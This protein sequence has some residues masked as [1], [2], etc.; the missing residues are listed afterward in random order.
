VEINIGGP[1]LTGMVEAVAAIG[2][3][4]ATIV[5][6]VAAIIGGFIANGQLKTLQNQLTTQQNNERIKN[7]FTQIRSYFEGSNEFPSPASASARLDK[8]PNDPDIAGEVLGVS[9]EEYVDYVGGSF[10][11]LQNYLDA[12]DDLLTRGLIDY[13]LFMSRQCKVIIASVAILRR[14]ATVM[15]FRHDEALL[16]RIESRALEYENRKT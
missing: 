13:D 3:C 6:A 10:V 7:T 9:P 15:D 11:A 4:I 14:F 16:A 2:T 8:I 1:A 12:S 5:L